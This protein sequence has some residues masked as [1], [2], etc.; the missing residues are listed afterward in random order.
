MFQCPRCGATLPPAALVCQFCGADVAK[1]PRH[2]PYPRGQNW[3]THIPQTAKWKIVVGHIFAGY[4]ILNGL[5]VAAVGAFGSFLGTQMAADGGITSMSD[6]A[7]EGMAL[8]GLGFCFGLVGLVQV[9]L[10]L[11]MILRWSWVPPWVYIIAG[12]VV[13]TDILS[14]ATG[15]SESAF[16]VSEQFISLALNLFLIYILYETRH[17]Y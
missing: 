12:F 5:F 9:L 7:A 14:L 3:H 2:S 16:Q 1:V 8:S 10:G 6:Q 17:E 13:I 4:W 15:R 11:G